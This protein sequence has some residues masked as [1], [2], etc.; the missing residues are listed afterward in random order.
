MRWWVAGLVLIVVL[1]I[2]AVPAAVTLLAAAAG[3]MPSE[4]FTTPA[5]LEQETE[6]GAEVPGQIPGCPV[7]GELGLPLPGTYY[8]SSGYGPRT[9]TIVGASTWHP[10]V[11]LA[12]ACGTPVMAMQS[13]VV[14]TSNRLWL[15][16]RSEAGQRISYLHTEKSSRSVDVGDAVYAGQ[17]IATVGNVPPSSGCHLDVRIH[18]GGSTD[19]RVLSLV[20]LP[21]AGG[22]IH[23]EQFTMLFGIQLCPPDLCV[24]LVA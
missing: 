20:P 2:V 3:G 6:A 23:P 18:P 15:T 7:T 13:G 16:I 1:P 9:M 10:A 14:V 21:G 17:L 11:D 4:C 12:A 5:V 19:E 24:R 8:L 22:Y